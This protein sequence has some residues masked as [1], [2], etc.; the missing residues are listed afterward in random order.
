MPPRKK[1]TAVVMDLEAS[2]VGKTIVDPLNSAQESGEPSIVF[3]SGRKLGDKTPHPMNE[4]VYGKNLPVV[5]AMGMC[6]APKQK[7]TIEEW[8]ACKYFIQGTKVIKIECS[9][10]NVFGVASDDAISE[11]SMT[12]LSGKTLE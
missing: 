2:P 9:I 3:Y 8:I 4:N 11:F 1:A 7:G 5:V 12:F 6:K 10:P